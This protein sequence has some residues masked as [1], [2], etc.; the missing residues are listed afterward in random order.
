MSWSISFIGTPEKIVD[1]L[2][3]ESERLTGASKEEF[4]RVVPN[5]M[6]IVLQNYTTVPGATAPT[7]RVQANGHGY[8]DEK[9]E[10]C[11]ANVEVKTFHETIL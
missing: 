8:K 2:H 11:N 10:Y 6:G 4:D 9:N 5:I 3:K 7:L 1:A